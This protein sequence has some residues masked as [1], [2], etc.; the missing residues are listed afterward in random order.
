A[1]HTPTAAPA[2][3]R[4]A[5][6][7]LSAA[8]AR[9]S[10]SAMLIAESDVSRSARAPCRR[11]RRSNAATMGSF[12]GV[13]TE[14]GFYRTRIAVLACCA[15]PDAFRRPSVVRQ[16][17]VE[18][19]SSRTP[20]P[21]VAVTGIGAVSGFGWGLAALEAGLLSG[22]T[23]IG[24]VTRFDATRYPTHIAAEVP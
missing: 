13:R 12:P 5:A 11:A 10:I 6:S 8:R 17:M 3:R 20:L 15:H 2:G 1:P 21:R 22:R 14:K 4:R 7:D 23:A 24:P 9:A 19:K 18:A 16:H